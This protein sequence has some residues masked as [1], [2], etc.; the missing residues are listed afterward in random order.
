MHDFWRPLF[1][2]S[3]LK[4]M[5]I[6][7]HLFSA[8]ASCLSLLAFAAVKAQA[9]PLVSILNLDMQKENQAAAL[10]ALKKY[11]DATRREKGVA[12]V[13]A[14]QEDFWGSRF[15]V[16]ERWDSPETLQAHV[17]GLA[18][19]ALEDSWR[20]LRGSPFDRR[21]FALL[22]AGPRKDAGAT[23]PVYLKMHV[24]VLPR[25]LDTTLAAIPDLV[26]AGGALEGS[27]R[28]EASQHMV[29]PTSHLTI[30]TGW[31]S[32][33]ALEQFEDSPAARQFRKIIGPWTGS[34]FDDRIY[35]RIGD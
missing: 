17:K 33:A 10:A 14:L 5:R 29:R 11:R 13:L 25:G 32:K 22:A 18:D 23:S 19:Q 26:K 4:R 28:F 2:T 35:S 16:Y 3:H 9:D 12:E 31:S 7:V 6:A 8:L 21:Q 27:L 30:L 24:D 1:G 15:F 34:P 20:H